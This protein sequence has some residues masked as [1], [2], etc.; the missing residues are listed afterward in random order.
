MGL[1]RVFLLESVERDEDGSATFVGARWNSVG[2]E[3]EA[4]LKG[5][6]FVPRGGA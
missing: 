6:C 2:E 1:S 4:M 5:D 3:V